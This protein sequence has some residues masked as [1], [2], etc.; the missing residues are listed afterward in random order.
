MKFS[1]EKNK[2][3]KKLFFFKVWVENDVNW[4]NIIININNTAN[5]LTIKRR[6]IPSKLKYIPKIKN[7]VNKNK[8]DKNF[9][10]TEVSCRNE[11]RINN[12]KTKGTIF[13]SDNILIK[14]KKF[15]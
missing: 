9:F 11:L 12:P 4:E 1:R 7:K 5:S 10:L 2:I 8:K 14:F 6:I 13:S 15:I 3:I